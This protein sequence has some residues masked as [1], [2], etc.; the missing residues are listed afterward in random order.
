MVAQTR[1]VKFI[2]KTILE[3]FLAL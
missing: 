2:N 1:N 3:P